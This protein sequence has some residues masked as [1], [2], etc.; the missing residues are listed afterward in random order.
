MK[1]E[2]LILADFVEAVN[3]KLYVMGGGWDQSRN[4]AYPA[5]IRAGIAVGLLVP[6]E[7]TN[8]RISVRLTVVDEDGNSVVPEIGSEVEVGRA[9]GV[10][11][12]IQQRAVLAIN[13]MF[14]VPRP[15]R[16][17]IVATAGTEGQELRVTFEALLAGG[18]LL[19]IG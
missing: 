6:W 8:E 16:Y 5:T 19:Q 15:A 4:Q 7:Q 9:P 13:A 1:L 11:P 17:E 10:R 2:F 12:G 14:P 3:G 18:P